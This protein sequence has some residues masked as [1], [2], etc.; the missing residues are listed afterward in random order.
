MS[1]LQNPESYNQRDVLSLKPV[2]RWTAS[3]EEIHLKHNRILQP[4][5]SATKPEKM[6][7]NAK[8]AKEE[9][10]TDICCPT[11]NAA[12][13]LH[14]SK[15]MVVNYKIE[16]S[17]LGNKAHSAYSALLAHSPEALSILEKRIE[18]RM[19]AEITDDQLKSK[20]IERLKRNKV[21]LGENGEFPKATLEAAIEIERDV[22]RKNITN[23]ITSEFVKSQMPV[24][25]KDLSLEPKD[26]HAIGQSNDFSFLGAAGSGKSTIAR[27]FL[28]DQEK[29][30][31][32]V[33]A[34][35]NYRAFSMPG[36]DDHEVRSTKDVF[37]RT[38]DMA[39]MVK[40]LVQDEINE[41]VKAGKRPNIICDCVTLEGGMKKLL[42]Q[43]K[44]TSVIA[45][46]SGEPGY[47]G[48]V[49]RADARARDE[50]AAPADKGRFVNTTSLLEGH[51]NA[52]SRLLTSIPEKGITTLYDTNVERGAKPIEIGQIDS[53]A[54][55]LDI[56]DLRTAA[57]FLNKRN[58][59]AEAVNQVDL[60]YNTKNPLNTL[61]THPENQAKSIID[62]VP[63]TKFK[64]AFTVNLKDKD[65]I[66]YASLV[67]G[68][69]DGTVKLVVHKKEKFTEKAMSTSVEGALLR[70]ITRQVEKGG[71]EQSLN[72]ALDKGDKGSFIEA[73]KS[74]GIVQ[75]GSVSLDQANNLSS[76]RR[77]IGKG[78]TDL[79]KSFDQ[80]S[81]AGVRQSR[82]KNVNQELG[83]MKQS[84]LKGKEQSVLER[85]KQFG[86]VIKKT[87]PDK[88]VTPGVV[89]T[90][91]H[92][93]KPESSQNR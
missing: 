30:N 33:L 39:Y 76:Y 88:P 58:I 14:L 50:H 48:I 42:A 49:E 46:Y 34:T 63:K 15:E 73:A 31:Y 62:L 93:R 2:S 21:S 90:A 75:E 3:E 65:G 36:T 89:H 77:E 85:A 55:T 68:D 28:S 67:P 1:K 72:A 19:S 41:Q 43:G 53:T 5:F 69:K 16:E 6:I 79:A 64:P 10:L 32:A 27:Q 87:Q 40:E 80:G 22:T 12:L 20:A 61:S 26:T 24:I 71:L 60:I 17:A 37:T 47:T 13:L 52:S 78:V 83:A 66:S 54:Q 8:L 86:A 23:E 45:A 35:D 18:E 29:S 59:N 81:I 91:K 44:T 7:Q 9:W 82:D 56:I 57:A 4:G 74:F 84:V 70:S 25:S 11:A 92:T 51:G 38:Q